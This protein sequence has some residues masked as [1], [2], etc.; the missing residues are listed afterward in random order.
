MKKIKALQPQATKE[1]ST[2]VL[3]Q[4]RQALVV[5]AVEA[6]PSVLKSVINQ[7]LKG[8]LEASKLV[9]RIAGLDLNTGG[10]ARGQNNLIQINVTPQEQAQLE[11]DFQELTIEEE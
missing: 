6:S 5:E 11:H 10:G 8:D 9:F 1:L 7:A 4:K 3:E 2:E